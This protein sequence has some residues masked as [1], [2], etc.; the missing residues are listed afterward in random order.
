M[1]T[2]ER[3]GSLVTSQ[4]SARR[5]EAEG[6]IGSELGQAQRLT[7]EDATAIV[8]TWPEAP[9]KAAEKLLDH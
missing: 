6:S 2:H 4:C 3:V 7:L 5:F 1:P 8:D 9:K